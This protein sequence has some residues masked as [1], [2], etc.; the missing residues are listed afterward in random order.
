MIRRR[1]RSAT[2]KL[3]GDP[4]MPT[5]LMFPL[6]LVLLAGFVVVTQPFTSMGDAR[7]PGFADLLNGGAAMVLFVLAA[8]VMLIG[9]VRARRAR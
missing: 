4:R 2:N 9:R 1:N 7:G 5:R 8:I 6:V 3:E